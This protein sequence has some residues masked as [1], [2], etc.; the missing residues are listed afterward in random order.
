MTVL[1]LKGI[2]FGS[3]LRYIK[4]NLKLPDEFEYHSTYSPNEVQAFLWDLESLLGPDWLLVY[5]NVSKS[6]I[7]SNDFFKSLFLFTGYS[8]M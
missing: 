1:M 5:I 2:C 6:A 8:K 3:L 4:E 7:S